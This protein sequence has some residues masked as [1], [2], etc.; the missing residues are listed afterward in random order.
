M[1]LRIQPLPNLTLPNVATHTGKL[2]ETL[3]TIDRHGYATLVT[4]TE[5]KVLKKSRLTGEPT[6]AKYLNLRKITKLRVSVHHNYQK[7]VSNRQGKVGGTGTF[8]T[9]PAKGMHPYTT[10]R[11]V[12]QSDRNANQLYLRYYIIVQSNNVDVVYIDENDLPVEISKAEK[13]EYFSGY[14]SDGSRPG[15]KKQA[16]VGIDEENQIIVRSVKLENVEYF[17][18]G[19]KVYNTLPPMVMDILNLG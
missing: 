7:S 10:N 18:K 19:D 4:V 14:K 13:G 3:N 17:A 11:V 8:V 6:P 12:W 1:G 16:S 9:E 5:V 2:L 15:S